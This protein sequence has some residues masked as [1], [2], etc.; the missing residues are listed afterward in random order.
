MFGL[1]VV[2]T[3]IIIVI[4]IVLFGSQ[5]PKLVSMFFKT[6]KDIKAEVDKGVE[7]LKTDKKTSE[8]K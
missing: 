4:A 1:G 7:E 2:E 3:V 6:T 8:K 5:A